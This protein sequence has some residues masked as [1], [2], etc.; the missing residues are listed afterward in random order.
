MTLGGRIEYS[1]SVQRNLKRFFFFAAQDT[2][3]VKL[4]MVHFFFF[5]LV[6]I[7]IHKRKKSG[8]EASSLV[9]QK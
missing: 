6:E 2:F 9:E 3:L 5:L 4:K 1:H 8:F 7:Q